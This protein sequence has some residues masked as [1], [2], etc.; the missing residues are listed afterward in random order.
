MHDSQ[1][2]S[3]TKPLVDIADDQDED[4]EENWASFAEPLPVALT[5]TH[6]SDEERGA[7]FGELDTS[8]THASNETADTRFF[9]IPHSVA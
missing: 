4:D 5:R 1:L 8:S 9:A 3:E 6:I 2:A 7:R